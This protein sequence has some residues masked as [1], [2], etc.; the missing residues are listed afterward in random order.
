MVWCSHGPTI[1]S[2]FCN[3]VSKLFCLS[4]LSTDWATDTERSIGSPSSFELSPEEELELLRSF[5]IFKIKV[6]WKR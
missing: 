5:S 1:T 2:E 4:S 6:E 3:G